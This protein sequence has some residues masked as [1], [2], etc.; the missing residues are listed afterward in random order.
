MLATLGTA[1]AIGE[2]GG[3]LSFAMV[4]LAWSY[5]A[6]LEESFMAQNFGAAYLQYRHEVNALVPF[7]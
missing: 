7:V 3:L 1:I 4:T 5:K 6:R 2:A